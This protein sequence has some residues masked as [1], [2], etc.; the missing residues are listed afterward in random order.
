[1]ISLM[2]RLYS[3]SL[4]L[5]LG[6]L[7]SV[8]AQNQGLFIH[9][10][11]KAKHYQGALVRFIGD[12]NGDGVADYAIG[13]ASPS[14]YRLAFTI[15][16]GATGMPRLPLAGAATIAGSKISGRGWQGRLRGQHEPGLD[17]G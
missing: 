12:T 15:Y 16:S 6:L 3:S 17:E 9:S 7:G 11:T 13:S 14:W 5:T 4:A 8:A 1:M 2:D 10:S